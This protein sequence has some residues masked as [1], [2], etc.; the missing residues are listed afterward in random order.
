MIPS[1]A[2]PIMWINVA[3]PEWATMLAVL[4]TATLDVVDN[5]LYPNLFADYLQRF[6]GISFATRILLQFLL[7]ASCALLNVAGIDQV[8]SSGVLLMVFSVLP[9][10]LLFLC[11]APRMT[12]SHWGDTPTTVDWR[13]FL[14]LI[15]WN[16]SGFDNAGHVVEEVSVPG[17]TLVKALVMLLILSQMVYAMPV[18]AGVSAAHGGDEG[19]YSEWTDGYW[20]PVAGMIGG[21]WLEVAMVL[22]GAVSAFGFT[23]CALCTTSRAFQ[24]MCTLGCFT[25]S[26]NKTFGALHPTRRTPVN[27]IVLNAIVTFALT[28]T[29]NFEMLVSVEQVLYALRLIMVLC[30]VVV[31]R[32]K[33][34]SL[35]RPY[36]IPGGIAGLVAMISAPILWACIVVVGS[37]TADQDSFDSISTILIVT[38]LV[39]Y[40]STRVHQ[41]PFDGKI[42]SLTLPEMRRLNL[43]SM[44]CH[45][46]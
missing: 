14:P 32:V 37:V 20:V 22:G 10:L 27:A 41:T 21:T 1:N 24:G 25:A 19:D 7:I 5:S 28:V 26:I 15:S 34:P 17:K 31:L 13:A 29:M 44:P 45:F 46:V 35:H 36:K 2:G 40:L 6:I 39:A 11:E 9:F 38:A 30:S 8:G 4:W 12:S 18:L 43:A 33:H 42:V 3:L 23:V 16:F